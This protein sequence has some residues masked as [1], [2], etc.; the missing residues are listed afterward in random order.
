VLLLRSVT[1][2]LIFILYDN[3]LLCGP[4]S[5]STHEQH[6]LT[7]PQTSAA[8]TLRAFTRYLKWTFIKGTHILVRLSELL[9]GFEW[10]SMRWSSVRVILF[11]VLKALQLS[12][13]LKTTSLF[14]SHEIIFLLSSLW[15][16]PAAVE[17]QCCRL[18]SLLPLRV[19]VAA[20]K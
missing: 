9:G 15:V 17:I 12:C 14:D 5:Q 1:P 2:E 19:T 3:L 10:S 16:I 13:P 11:S 18:L 20:L 4:D 7:F 8:L 6:I